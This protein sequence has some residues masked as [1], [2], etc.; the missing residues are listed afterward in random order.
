MH[1]SDDDSDDSDCP[2]VARCS[3]G[4]VMIRK[5]I[6]RDDDDAV[7]LRHANIFSNCKS[8]FATP[9]PSMLEC[10]AKTFNIWKHY[11]M[12]KTMPLDLSAEDLQAAALFAGRFCMLEFA[13]ALQKVKPQKTQFM[14]LSLWDPQFNSK[15]MRLQRADW[16]LYYSDSTHSYYYRRR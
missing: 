9:P 8:P 7:L 16:S 5:R 4:P 12:T 14:S 10:T 11:A 2:C 6:L 15:V 1:N 13:H 3:D